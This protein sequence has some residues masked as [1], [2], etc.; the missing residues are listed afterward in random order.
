MT[1]AA[2]RI[3]IADDEP[4]LL[5]ML[6]V[7]LERLGYS[8]V[9][10]GSTEEAWAEVEAA[11]DAFALAVLDASMSGIC[12][13]D[14][15]TRMLAAGPRLCVIAASGYPVDI[16]LLQATAPDRVMFLH[17]PFSPEMLGNAVRRMIAT[18]E[19]DV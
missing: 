1:S 15:A 18:Q 19:A 6:G 10:A 5:K 13:E 16:A 9:T 14:L 7:Y 8:V 12:M 2:S 11:P 4:S 17:K 3:L